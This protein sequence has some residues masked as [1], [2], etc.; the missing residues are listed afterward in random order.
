MPEIN[1]TLS[2]ILWAI[3]QN[4]NVQV[5][6]LARNNLKVIP[7]LFN[8]TILSKSN[9]KT[10]WLGGNPV[11]C[12]CDMV[13]LISWLNNTRISGRRL[14]QDYQHVICRGG[15]WDGIPVYKLD[16]VNMGCYPEKV[17]TWIIAASTAIGGMA[18]LTV[19]A[20]ILGYR[21]WVLI[22]WLMYKHF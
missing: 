18:L 15:K 3:L 20:V 19:V 21:H 11:I 4:A 9:L 6:N 10:I 12:N 16:K 17:A 7:K 1:A 13:W 22:R 14:V 5:L 2:N 8:R